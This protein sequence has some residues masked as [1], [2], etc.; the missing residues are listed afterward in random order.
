MMIVCGL[1]KASVYRIYLFDIIHN[2]FMNVMAF[3][4]HSL[5]HSQSQ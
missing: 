1:V 3:Q 2:E 5:S 4:F